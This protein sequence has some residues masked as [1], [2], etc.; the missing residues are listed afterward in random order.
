MKKIRILSLM[1]ALLMLVGSFAACKKEETPPP[2]EPASS[3]ELI[4]ASVTDYVIVYDNNASDEVKQWV[5]MLVEQFKVFFGT[6]IEKRECFPD[7]ENEENDIEVEK[8]ILV[9]LTNRK[10]SIDTLKD[11][12]SSDYVIGTYGSKLVIGGSTEA[13]T[14]KALALFVNDY[15]YEIGDKYTI[16]EGKTLDFVFS[17]D[18]NYKYVATTYSY[19][20]CII[21]GAR[22]DSFSLIYANSDENASENKAFADQLQTHISKQAGYLLDVLKDTAYWA[23]Y[24]ILVGNTLYS[25][26]ALAD[27][28]G[29]DEYHI[30]LSKVEVTYEDGSKHDGAVIQILY[31]KDAKD[32]AFNAFKANFIKASAKPI[33]LNMTENL[34]ITNKA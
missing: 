15:V 9:G 5:N 2:A 30:S 13:A 4:K 11:L 7:I 19:S 22:I 29:D 34:V 33:E 27:S 17:S 25:D 28:L 6:D 1:L 24:Q 32:A 21:M 26:N 3:I 12:R 20:K 10:E 23:D 14:A 31:G 8:E 18:Q 16:S